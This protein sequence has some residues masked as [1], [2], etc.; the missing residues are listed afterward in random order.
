MSKETL[1]HHNQSSI[2]SYDRDLA[3]PSAR[4]VT[5][6]TTPT[7]QQQ[8]PH[9]TAAPTDLGAPALELNIGEHGKG[10]GQLDHRRKHSPGFVL[11]RIDGRPNM[12]QEQTVR[13][14]SDKIRVG[15]QQRCGFPMNQRCVVVGRRRIT[16]AVGRLHHGPGAG[17]TT[18]RR[19]SGTEG[20]LYA[21]C[22]SRRL[23]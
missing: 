8:Q 12:A 15:R 9:A 21:E 14:V 17:T 13:F 2:D 5:R 20:S 16:T 4:V 10:F 19:S 11:R 6:T 3:I 22:R 18:T 7:H 1:D 23:P